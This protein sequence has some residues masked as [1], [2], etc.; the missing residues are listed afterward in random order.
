M[1]I[2]SEN[3]SAIARA[4]PLFHRRLPSTREMVNGKAERDRSADDP[5]PRSQR[6][7]SMI[8]VVDSRVDVD[9]ALPEV[10]AKLTDV[11][12]WPRWG[13]TVESFAQ[14]TPPPMQVGSRLLQVR[15]S[16]DR[17]IERPF[18]VTA[19]VSNELFALA[20]PALRC[21]F[22]LAP[23]AQGTRV[24]ARFRVEAT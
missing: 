19:F 18:E 6:L 15:R 3:A 9:R 17:R 14:I 1:C 4:L 20:S 24:R 21:S 8:I 16:G 2:V 10:F 22:E 11:G 13:S 5:A 23:R 12:S 7:S